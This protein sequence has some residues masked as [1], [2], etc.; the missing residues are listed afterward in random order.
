MFYYIVWSQHCT[1]FYHTILLNGWIVEHFFPFRNLKCCIV[2][3]QP[4]NGACATIRLRCIINTIGSIYSSQLP[5]MHVQ[6]LHLFTITTIFNAHTPPCL[7][8]Q[9]A[10]AVR[11]TE[12]HIFLHTSRTFVRLAGWF[13]VVVRCSPI[14]WQHLVIEKSN[15]H[16]WGTKR[17]QRILWIVGFGLT[18]TIEIATW[19]LIGCGQAAGE[20]DF[21]V[22][23]RHTIC[24]LL[25]V[26]PL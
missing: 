18:L 26:Y 12:L 23:L 7:R 21:C 5:A 16:I 4:G 20:H 19:R 3:L 13:A 10:G 17:F 8:T 14:L 15:N 22:K 11:D 1:L 24:G 2:T 25:F 9:N 6:W